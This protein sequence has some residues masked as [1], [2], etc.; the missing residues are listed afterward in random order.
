ME[1]NG[2]NVYCK[3][4]EQATKVCSLGHRAL[5]Q[6]FGHAAN[7]LEFLSAE[8]CVHAHVHLPTGMDTEHNPP[9]YSPHPPT[10]PQKYAHESVN[11]RC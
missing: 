5:S 6:G 1:A 3:G 2:K 7:E 9:T 8:S 4:I 10:Y 11:M